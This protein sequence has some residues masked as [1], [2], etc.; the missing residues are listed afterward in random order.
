MEI[1][2]GSNNEVFRRLARVL[3]MLALGLCVSCIPLYHKKPVQAST[4]SGERVKIVALQMKT[5]EKMK[6]SGGADGF[7]RPG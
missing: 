7:A 5:G 2:R 3:A 4:V 6:F 1:G